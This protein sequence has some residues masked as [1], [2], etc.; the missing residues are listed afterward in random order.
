MNIDFLD[1][2]DDSHASIG[3]QT[4]E[5]SSSLSVTGQ[6]LLEYQQLERALHDLSYPTSTGESLSPFGDR[7]RKKNSSSELAVSINV[8]KTAVTFPIPFSQQCSFNS[9]PT[10]S[11]STPS[12]LRHSSFQM[13]SP[14]L[15][16]H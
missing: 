8:Q 14:Y 4:M 2:F 10:S 16:I 13:S 1:P 7:T 6:K 15:T 9:T 11:C 5:E 12:A 3:Q